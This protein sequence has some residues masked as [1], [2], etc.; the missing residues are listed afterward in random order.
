MTRGFASRES[1]SRGR[2]EART[3]ERK[4]SRVSTSTS[5][6]ETSIVAFAR[7]GDATPPWRR[8]PIVYPHPPRWC[9]PR[10]RRAR[11]ARARWEDARGEGN[12]RE[13][14]AR[15]GGDDARDGAR[16]VRAR[17]E[18]L[19][20]VAIGGRRR[21]GISVRRLGGRFAKTTVTGGRR[22]AVARAA[23][24]GVVPSNFKKFTEIFANLFPIWTILAA[25]AGVM[26]PNTFSFMT[27]GAYIGVLGALDVL[28]GDH[29]HD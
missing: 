13:G 28:H 1:E 26:R 18:T 15:N 2:P 4:S 19:D 8:S 17:D 22:R 24:G 16:R 29:A 9:R 10:R 11:T 23:D 5:D 25:V 20:T 7:G 6:L 3:N 12:A 27:S 21:E 14:C